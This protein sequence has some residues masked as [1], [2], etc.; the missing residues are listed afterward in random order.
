MNLHYIINQIVSKVRYPISVFLGGLL[1]IYFRWY[2]M[3]GMAQG[4]GLPDPTV[5]L[6]AR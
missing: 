6:P 3:Y 5:N 4:A 2:T 1:V